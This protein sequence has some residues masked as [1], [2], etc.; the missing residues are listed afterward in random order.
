MSRKSFFLLVLFILFVLQANGQSWSMTG[1]LFD[2]QVNPLVSGTVVLLNPVDS[3][4]EFF[5]ITNT[6]GQFEI[7]NIKEGSYLLQASFM[8]FHTFYN[9]VRIPRAEGS[10][11]GD[12]V[13]QPLPVDLEGAEVVGEAVPLQIHGD[14]VVYNAAAFKTRPDAMTEE[15]LK[16][17]PGVEV[18][19][20]GNIKA[21]GEDVNTVYVD[22]KEFFG[23]DPTVATRNIPADAISKVKVYD[24]KSD[25]SEFTGI[26]DGRRNKTINLELKEDKKKGVFGDVLA[27]YGT[28]Q[29]YKA[30]GKVY[31][32]TDKIQ[33]AGLGMINNVNEYGFSFNDYLDFNG[34]IAAMKGGGGSAKISMGGDNAFPINFGQPVDGL[35]TTGA[36]GLNFSYSTDKHNRTYISYLINGSDK[37][38]EQLTRTERYTEEGSFTTSDQTVQNTGNMAHRI[39][40]GLRRRIDSTHNLIFSGNMGLM[41]NDLARLQETENMIGEELVSSLLSDRVEQSDRISGNLSGTYYR[42]IGKNKSVLKFSADGNFSKSLDQIRIDNQID[43]TSGNEPDLFNQY[44]DNR[45]DQ[46][47]LSLVA[48]Y[49]QKI[50]KGLYLDPVVRLGGT[51]E[52]LDR[53]QGPLD[54]GMVPVDSVSPAF[55]KDYRWIR[56]GFN[57]RWNTKKSQLS[58]G[59]MAEFGTLENSLN[60]VPYPEVALRYFTPTFSW[61]Y[62]A[63]AGRKFNIYYSSSVNT[64]TVN[65]LLPVVNYLNPLNIYY[66]NPSL[67]PEYN[68]NLMVH[69]LI[70]DQFSFTSFMMALSGGYTSDKINWS[71]T[72]TDDLVQISTLTNVDWDYRSRLNLDFSTPIR[73]L[74]IKVNLDV[75]ESWNRGMN[76]VNDVHNIYNTLNHRYSLSADNRKKKKWDVESGVGMT[77]TNTWYDIQ[78]SLNNRYFDLSWFAD[79]R[80]T[81]SEKWHFEVTA[82]VTSYSDLGVDESIQ[83]PLLRAEASYFFLAH[84]RG[85]LTLSGFDLLDRNQNVQRI[86]ELNYLRET[87]SNTMGRYVMLTFKYRLN[88]MAR[89]GGIKVDMHKRR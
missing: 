70:F 67:A 23:S 48:A 32:F 43:Y 61:D 79:I 86:S 77:L 7:R 11:V 13:M 18:D 69:W 83:V 52:Q 84:N 9:P 39:N 34:G 45:T 31:R 63:A 46:G 35:A 27:G 88:K 4:M 49:T 21:L 68:H 53:M 10:D 22:G 47:S 62:S 26:D 65:Q 55:N 5:G 73:K 58:V 71:T 75:E 19:R 6:Q 28:G 1:R 76:L 44:Q 3:T 20:A 51:L 74:G 57:F 14:T 59:I 56:P 78:E 15:L 37:D 72:V 54:N 17:L 50:G 30:S 2:D 36:G 16:K 87:R 24:K 8:G 33:M 38:L 85:V 41:Y 60:Q 89:E 66:G 82:D 64:P 81:P 80:Y 29:H 12:I 42:M 40:F 25:E